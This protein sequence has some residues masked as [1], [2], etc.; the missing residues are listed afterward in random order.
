MKE[1]RSLANSDGRAGAETIRI[2][3]KLVKKPPTYPLPS[4]ARKSVSLK[5]PSLFGELFTISSSSQ[6]SVKTNVVASILIEGANKSK[7]EK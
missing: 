1:L 4:L 3:T 2:D 7:I 6:N 5:Q